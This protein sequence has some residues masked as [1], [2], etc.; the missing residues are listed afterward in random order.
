M[1][2][3]QRVRSSQGH[4]AN[5]DAA[6]FLR[7]LVNSALQYVVLAHLSETNNLP[8]VALERVRQELAAMPVRFEIILAGQQGPT[9]MF[10]LG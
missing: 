5:G 8:E 10:P 1:P 2:L 6:R 9:A 4:L 3:K 7:E